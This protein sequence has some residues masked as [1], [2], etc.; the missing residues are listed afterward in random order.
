[1]QDRLRYP[2]QQYAV[3][4]SLY[5]ISFAPNK[6]SGY[7][8]IQRAKNVTL[9]EYF[10]SK[11]LYIATASN[12]ESAVVLQLQNAAMYRE[13]IKEFNAIGQS[14]RADL[15]ESFDDGKILIQEQDIM[16]YVATPQKV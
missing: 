8:L 15:L 11:P 6:E 2:A 1:L 5:I 12:V 14:I 10:T 9:V 16:F 3:N 7:A 4:E 13:E